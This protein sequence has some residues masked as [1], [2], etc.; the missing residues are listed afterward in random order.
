MKILKSIILILLALVMMVSIFAGCSSNENT[1]EALEFNNVLAQNTTEN[2]TGTVELVND[3]TTIENSYSKSDINSS[4]EISDS[5]V[6]TLADDNTDIAGNGASYKDGVLNITRAGTYIISGS[7]N[8]QIIID[9]TSV[10]EV[11]IVL[12]NAEIINKN[13]SAIYVKQAEKVT[14]TLADKSVN[15]VEDG[16]NYVD[17]SSDSPDAAIY[18]DDDLTIN[19]TGSLSVIGN[20]KHG[21][22]CSDNLIVT[23]G[24]INVTSINDGIRGKDSV[25]ILDGNITVDAGGDGLTATN[26][27]DASKGWIKVDGGIFNITASNNGFQAESALNIN[28]GEINVTAG[29]D[30]YHCNNDILIAGGISTLDAGDDGMHADNI[31]QIASGNVNVVSDYEG[32][33]GSSVYISGGEIAI[34]AVDDGINAAGGSDSDIASNDR[35]NMESGNNVISIS[36][37]NIYVSIIGNEGDGLDSNGN[38]YLSGGT[39]V[40]DGGVSQRDAAIDINKGT[41]EYSGGT[42]ASVGSTAMLVIPTTI[43]QPVLTILF[44]NDQQPDETIAIKDTNGNTIL[45]FTPKKTYPVAMLSNP[46]LKVGETYTFTMDGKELFTITLDQTTVTVDVDGN[47]TEA[48]EMSGPGGMRPQGPGGEKMPGREGKGG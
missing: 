7:L 10:D 11:Q 36:N 32:I 1:Q 34:E 17:S 31:L 5:T 18:A 12:G 45:S 40:I 38:I 14:L 19:G 42:L 20:F 13:G 15:Y 26:A 25:L 21:I 28:A 39:I 16:N 27:E 29:Q 46:K 6:I 41:F 47:A 2:A 4:Y 35:F 23:S 43:S 37:G 30:T 22:K 44:D 9:A 33:E 48:P 24:T 8:G 3:I